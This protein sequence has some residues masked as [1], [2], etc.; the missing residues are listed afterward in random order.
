MP[1]ERL[2]TEREAAAALSLAPKTLAR[3]RWRGDRGPAYVKLGSA[4]RYKLAD[5]E[6]F[7]ASGVIA[8]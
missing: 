5:L 3:W 7:I 2:L 1:E 8:R 6:N 4:V